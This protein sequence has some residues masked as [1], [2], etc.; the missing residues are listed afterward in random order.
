[1]AAY[2]F[3][4]EAERL[5]QEELVAGV[6]DTFIKERF[7]TLVGKIPF[8]QSDRGS[9]SWNIEADLSSNRTTQNSYSRSVAST[10]ATN[11]D[12][13]VDTGH[14]AVNADTPFKAVAAHS[15]ITPVRT[16]RRMK[17]S[18]RLVYDWENQLCNGMGLDPNLHGLEYYLSLYGGFANVSGSPTRLDGLQSGAPNFPF[19]KIFWAESND[20]DTYSKPPDV[21]GGDSSHPLTLAALRELKSRHPG[22]GP[23]CFLT[24]R[25]CDLWIRDLYQNESGG[26]MPDV[27][28]DPDFGMQMWQ[29][30]GVPIVSFDH[31]L[32][33][34]TQLGVGAAIGGS[35]PY[36]IT[37]S[38]TTGTQTATVENPGSDAEEDFIGFTDRVI[39]Q[40]I[41]L[42]PSGNDETLQI[43]GVNSRREVVVESPSN[44]YTNAEFR[45]ERQPEL[46]YGVTFDPMDGLCF[47]YNDM[48]GIED[49]LGEYDSDL[50]AMLGFIARDLGELQDGGRF[51]RD[52]YDIMGTFTVLQQW[53]ISRLSHFKKPTTY[54]A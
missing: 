21:D 50:S 4:T 42:D 49:A 32:E 15:D 11:W 33:G 18:K 31:A 3:A 13:E 6:A 7:A 28:G 37:I 26:T 27:Y 23:D 40:N 30:E 9:K 47:T 35:D 1:M 17:A 10:D 48:D 2:D 24:T 39:G 53:G 44:T 36:G 54:P 25:E 5:S 8:V 16:D 34:I 46:V 43:L 51:F 20:Q 38:G 41:N 45:V 29:F 12:Y 22:M 19:R 14:L 52:A